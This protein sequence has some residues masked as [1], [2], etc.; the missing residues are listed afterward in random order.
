MQFGD[1][2]GYWGV[3]RE[4]EAPWKF[5]HRYILLSVM[6]N[7]LKVSEGRLGIRKGFL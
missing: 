7:Y 5:S 3:S 4:F 6:R 2:T 1:L